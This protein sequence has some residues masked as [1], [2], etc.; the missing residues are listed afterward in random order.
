MKR[1]LWRIARWTWCAASLALLHVG[2]LA[3]AQDAKQPASAPAAA[4]P[5]SAPVTPPATPATP[6]AETK[7]G[8]KPA[9]PMKPGEK[10][11]EKPGDKSAEKPPEKPPTVRPNKPE[12]PANPDELKVR[13]DEKGLISLSF[14]GQPWPAVL[15]WLA[16]VSGMSLDWQEAPPD[17][18]DLTTR[19]RYT[20]DEVRDLIN[21]ALLAR[22]YSLLRNGEMLIVVN[23]KKLDSSLVPRVLPAELDERGNYELVKV[24]FDLNRLRAEAVVDELKPLLSTNGKVAAL[25]TTNRLDVLDT[26]GNLRRI[27]DL[28]SEE[29]S[30]SGKNFQIRE[31]RLRHTRAAEVLETLNSLLGIKPKG[32]AAPMTPE[33]MQAMQQ[34]QQQQMQMAQQQGQP[35]GAARRK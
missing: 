11:A 19:R 34:A 22:G 12:Q 23:L 26:A 15:Q 32:P 27:R 29:Q 3:S 4:A 9:E 35:G 16:D 2:T 33:Q 7:P 30:A 13:P 18:L 6:G 1:C 5:A 24:F 17:Y 14:K 21:S 31:F 10:P 25:K 20:V 8:D 28:L